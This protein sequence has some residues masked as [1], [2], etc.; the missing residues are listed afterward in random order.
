MPL[1]REERREDGL[2]DR[3]SPVDGKAFAALNECIG[4]LGGKIRRA[5]FVRRNSIPIALRPIEEGAR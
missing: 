1:P 3:R 2:L 4:G 5:P